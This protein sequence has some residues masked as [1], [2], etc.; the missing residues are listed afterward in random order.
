VLQLPKLWPCLGQLH[1][2][3]PENKNTKSTPSCCNCTL[4]EGEKSY[5][6][7]YRWCSHAKGEVQRR[8]VQ[9]A[10]KG[11]S[12]R[13]FFFKFTSPE[14]SYVDALR[15]DNQNQQQNAPQTEEKSIRHPVQQYMPQQ[16]FQQTG[17]SVQAHSSSNNTTVDIVVH[18]IM[19]ELSEAV[20]DKDRIMDIVTCLSSATNNCGFRIWWLDLS[21]SLCCSLTLLFS[22]LIIFFFKIRKVLVR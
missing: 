9:R 22:S 10:P 18:R 1:R 16:K 7:S 14:Q 17:L 2:E 12:G 5:P 11:P 8:K 13:K 6:A 20:S 19:T 4:V 21:V 15:Q 3:F